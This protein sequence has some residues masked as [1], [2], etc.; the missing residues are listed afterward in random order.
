[1]YLQCLHVWLFVVFCV[2]MQPLPCRF[3][4]GVCIKRVVQLCDECCRR[5]WPL[6]VLMSLK[7]IGLCVVCLQYRVV[8]PKLGC[9]SDLFSALSKLCG[10][11]PENV[12]VAM[13]LSLV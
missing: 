11:A 4:E 1:M 2:D 6:C 5:C 9:V 3:Q 10:I 8:V 12:S 13:L 7:M